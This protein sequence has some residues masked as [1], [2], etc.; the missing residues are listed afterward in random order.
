MSVHQFLPSLSPHDAI[1]NHVMRL[2]DLLRRRWPDSWLYADHFPVAEM[3]DQ[4]EHYLWYAQQARPGDVL[5][6]HASIDSPMNAWLMARPEPLVVVYHNVTPAQY[7]EAYDP[8]LARRLGLAREQ[9]A[10]LGGR[11]ALAFG[12]S[13]YNASELADWGFPE[14]GVLPIDIDLARYRQ[15]VDTGLLARLVAAKQD[16]PGIV[17]PGRLAPNKAQHDL[18]RAYRVVVEDHPSARLWCPGF[19]WSAAYVGA[20]SKYRAALGI[21]RGVFPGPATQAQLLAYYRAADVYLCLSDHEGFN[22]PAIEA[23]A[24]GVPVIAYAAAALPETVGDGGLLLDTKDPF[25][26]AA[27]VSRVFDDAE[28]RARMVA[29]GHARIAAMDFEA[30]GERFLDAVASLAG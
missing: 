14:P 23:M 29:A 28:L 16:G 12:V 22:V 24:M 10:A 1:G 17:F 26:V 8:F 5:V 19:P 13:R 3:A 25:V 2:R 6:Y 4:V 20:L 11:A 21:P 27:A 18:L 7:V 15:P 30:A 9:I